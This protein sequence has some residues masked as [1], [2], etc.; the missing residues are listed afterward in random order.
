MVFGLRRK[1]RQSTTAGVPVPT[2]V[3]SPV[4]QRKSLTVAALPQTGATTYTTENR[5]RAYVDETIAQQ[6]PAAVQYT[7][8]P[9]YQACTAQRM[10][11]P[12]PTGYGSDD[13]WARTAKYYS[14]GNKMLTDDN[15]SHTSD[16]DELY[17]TSPPC[18][19]HPVYVPF[20]A[21]PTIQPYPAY[22]YE[23]GHTH[24]QPLGWRELYSYTDIPVVRDGAFTPS[25][26]FDGTSE[27]AYTAERTDRFHHHPDTSHSRRRASPYY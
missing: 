25:H 7:P 20:T 16:N 3:S 4:P 21:Q 18:T 10:A 27:R 1:L 6:H 13:Q 22:E 15:S 19:R 2:R 24:Q 14:V 11:P 5:I 23:N 8:P 17:S 12:M 9:P 26:R